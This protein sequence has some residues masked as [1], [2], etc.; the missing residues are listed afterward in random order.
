M[1]VFIGYVALRLAKNDFIDSRMWR[2]KMTVSSA[3]VIGVGLF[4]L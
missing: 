3:M 2:L 1:A 4:Y